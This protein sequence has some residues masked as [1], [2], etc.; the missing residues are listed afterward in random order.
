MKK[1]TFS[2]FIVTIVAVCLLFTLFTACGAT[3]TGTSTGENTS[4]AAVE[5]SSSEQTTT[6]VAQSELKFKGKITMFAQAYHPVEPTK[7]NPNPPTQIKAI[8]K[9]YT[10]LHPGIEIEF[11]PSL[12]GQ[13]YNAWLKTKIAGGMAPDIFWAQWMDLNGGVF[14]KGSCID[15]NEYLSKPNPYYPEAAAWSDMFYPFVQGQIAGANGEHW[16]ID[17]DYVATAVIYNKALFAKAGIDKEPSNW[18]EFTEANKKLLAAGITPWAFGFGNNGDSRDRMTWLS[19]LFYTNFYSADFEK[20]AVA[21]STTSLNDLE[22]CVAFKKGL[23]GPKDP[24]W[25]GWWD[26]IK[27][28]AEYLQKDFTSAATTPDTVFNMFVN[29]QIAMYFDGSWAGNNLKN[30]NAS[31][32]YGSFAFPMPDPGCS[33]YATGFDSSGAIGGPNAAFQFCIA[34]PKADKDMT[35][36]KQ[37]AC[38]DWLMFITTPENNAAIVNEKGSFVPLVKGAKQLPANESLVK[39][40]EAQPLCIDGGLGSMGSNLLDVYYRTFQQYLAGKITLEDAAK[41]LQPVVDKA[42]E[43]KIRTSNLDLS[44]YIN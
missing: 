27:Q 38:A 22:A 3:N 33:Q 31:F 11:I 32:D 30:A 36:D 10:E 7:T 39:I 28:Q 42:V 23:F 18:S 20:L 37:D 40:F 12:E 2:K 29:Q 21:G 26:I 41:T 34:S 35:Q 5:Q 6:A 8:A 16:N 14:P 17:G 9:K 43:D 13:D 15:M 4:K 1:S 19:R 24:R 25:L 44:K